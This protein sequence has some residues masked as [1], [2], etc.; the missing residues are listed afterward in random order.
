MIQIETQLSQLRLNGMNR[1]W[2]AM[3][4]TRRH[5]ELSLQEGL[6]I[7][8]QAEQEERENRRF[9]R[10]RKNARFRYQAS[11]AEIRYD[12]SR[13]IDKDLI[14]RL[15]FGKYL[16][17]GE[18]VLITGSAGCGK[19]FIASALGHQACVQGFKVAYFNTKN[20]L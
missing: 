7:L 10:L 17:Q 3:Q 13:G 14:T 5:N 2:K 11:V 18:S 8:L 1:S 20:C 19:S 9:E 12:A 15:A 4:E 6:E 16:A